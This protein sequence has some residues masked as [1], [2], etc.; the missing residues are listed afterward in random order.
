MA[1][2]R[3][4][5]STTIQSAGMLAMGATGLSR[6]AS[7]ATQATTPVTTTVDYGQTRGGALTLV[8]SSPWLCNAVALT[9][10]GQ[11][12]MGLPRWQGSETTPS[13]G[14]LLPDG[15]IQPFP[16]GAW[17]T[18]SS[19]KP[20]KDAFV[21]VNT[22]HI[23]DD[24][25][26]WVVDQGTPFQGKMVDRDAFK[27]LQFDTRTG[28]L[29]RRLTFD[30]TTLPPGALLNDIRL[31][32]ENAYFTDSG[33]GAIVVVNLRSGRVLRRLA[34]HPSTKMQASR[35]PYAEDG[36]LLQQPDGKA[37]VTNSDPI[38]ISPDG[39]WLY[40]QPL[41]G[42]LYRVP[43]AALRDPN[44][45]EAALGAMV[46][47]V[48]DT[49]PLTGTAID[50]TGLLYFAEMDR[51]RITV[52]DPAAKR[53]AVLVEDTRLWGPDALFI[54]RQRE[55]YIPVPQ[56]HRVAANRGPHG[57]DLVQHPWRVY[58]IALPD[59]AGTQERVPAV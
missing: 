57:K 13:V 40:Y 45:S 56:S 54:S 39:N 1:S 20:T 26:L 24:D 11:T 10:K 17:N 52:Y 34:D 3:H 7:A 6:M 50:S 9:S 48:Y 41:T 55:L 38:E 44:L 23:F 27:I 53:L 8:A 22:I 12:F 2:R 37:A 31:D 16:G 18:W 51:P 47:M 14:K 36:Y 49:P 58:K 4:F 30:M 28:A 25:T 5:L 46:E 43:T 19:G 15:T 29:L 42:P 32:S 59:W 33:A 21:C 35:P